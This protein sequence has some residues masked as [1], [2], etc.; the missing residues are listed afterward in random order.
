SNSR[1]KIPCEY[2]VVTC[3]RKRGK[4][5]A[6]ARDIGA[7]NYSTSLQT[8]SQAIKIATVSAITGLRNVTEIAT[9]AAKRPCVSMRLRYRLTY[10]TFH[11][12]WV[13]FWSMPNETLR[14]PSF[15]RHK[16]D[17][18]RK[19]ELR[20]LHTRRGR[21]RWE[22]EVFRHEGGTLAGERWIDI[23]DSNLPSVA[24]TSA[25]RSSCPASRMDR[26]QWEQPDVRLVRAP[27]RRANFHLS[28]IQRATI[29]APVI[30]SHQLVM[31]PRT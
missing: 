4:L 20:I 1:F 21:A 2:A 23:A 15:G 3:I 12:A 14:D 8:T 11:R 22:T 19:R 5:R 31:P 25:S 7:L 30:A 6:R 26:F 16:V 27:A 9:P 24:R 29:H 13:G 28:R 10:D 18:P 17:L